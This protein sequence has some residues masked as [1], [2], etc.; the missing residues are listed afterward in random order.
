MALSNTAVPKY[1]GMFRD[2]VIRGDIP[3]CKEVSME[4]NRIDRLIRDPRY[5]YDDD[6]VEGWIAYCEGELTL[7][8]GSDLHL[9]DSFKLWGESVWG[10]YYFVEKS[11]YEPYP[12]G[13]GG[14]YVN[15]VIKKRLINKQYLIVGRGAAKS[16]YDS[17]QQSYTQNIDTSTTHQIT[18]APTMKQA[19][20]VMSPLRTAITRSKGPLFKFLTDGSLQNTTGSK[21]NRVKLASTK[22]G[23]ENFLTGSLIEV[24]PMSI[25]KLQGLRCKVATVDEWLSGDIREDVIGAIE[26][27][28]SKVDD[29]LIIAT[30]SEGTVRNGSGD[31]IKMELMD[32]LKGD[33]ENPHVSIWW[34]KLDSIDEVGMP[35]AWLKANPNIGKT[36]SYDTYQLD[37]ERAEKAPAARND[38]L[39]KRFGLP[40]EGYTYYFAYEET[41]PHKKR[42][43]WSMP[44]ALGADLSQG[45]DFCAFTFLFPLSNGAF[46]VKTR[47]Y[48][49]EYTLTKL[50]PALR[51]KY[52]EFI[53]EGSLIIM[54]GT[55]LDITRVY[56][57]L[58]EHIIKSDYDVR[59]FGYDPYNAK[60]FVER[61]QTEN[62]LFAI[63]KVP[64]GVKT[65]SVP[66]G[67][68]K[69]LAEGRQLIFDEE[70]MTFCMG[71]CITMEDT[72][73]N[74]KLL[75]K[76]YEQKIDSVAAMLDAYVAYKVNKDMFD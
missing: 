56:D 30:S 16:L 57:D 45:N 64:Q 67:E 47:N 44:C 70:L 31:T 28:A 48:I 6:A 55:N 66:L 7:T 72:N 3:V 21:A 51:T 33:Y 19:E 10:W 38:I 12:D 49:T 22:K 59:C 13:H 50:H 73:G 65:E 15:K 26:Q 36:V 41:L 35:E 37:V 42:D 29:Y 18:T 1:Y 11:I 2:A 61:W 27:G 74:R 17:C 60:E 76:R 4:M 63:E 46:G 20:E 39:A 14:H 25:N 23:I 62:G 75:K 58:D 52:E 43:F 40:M 34:Y 71:N 32:I 68:L 69:N 53:N 9:L 24:R 5:Y 54:P 8:D